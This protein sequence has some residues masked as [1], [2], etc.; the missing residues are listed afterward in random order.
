MNLSSPTDP[1][2]PSTLP[3]N[4]NGNV[5]PAGSLSRSAGGELRA[6]R[7]EILATVLFA[8]LLGGGCRATRRPAG[9]AGSRDGRRCELGDLSRRRRPHALLDAQADHQAQRRASS[10][11][12]GPTTPAT[13]ASIRRTTSSSTACS[14]TASPTRKVIALDAATGQGDLEIRP[15]RASVPA[16]AAAGSA[17]L[18]YWA[19]AR[20][21]GADLHR[22]RQLPLRARRE[23]RHADPQLRRE[24]LDPSRHRHRDATAASAST[25]GSTRRA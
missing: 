14:Y 13:K 1:A 2:R 8:V 3:Y 4:A 9:A 12:R 22:R 10:R 15:R 11:S 21:R 17:A 20:R 6:F 24:R 19:N 16:R 18:A 5:I 23:D 7:S 25:S